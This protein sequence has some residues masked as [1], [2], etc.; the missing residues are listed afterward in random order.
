VIR[1][2]YPGAGGERSGATRRRTTLARISAFVFRTIPTE[3]ATG[4]AAM[5]QAFGRMSHV[6]SVEPKQ[7][8]ALYPFQVAPARSA[9]GI[10]SGLFTI[11]PSFALPSAAPQETGSILECALLK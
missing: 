9:A 5:V 4:R 10:R 6:A 8:Q 7:S 1:R 3:A 2:S 11:A